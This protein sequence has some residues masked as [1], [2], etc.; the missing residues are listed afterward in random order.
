M[1]KKEAKT[2]LWVYD[3]LKEAGIY[4]DPQGCSIK[5]VDEA[6]KTASKKGTGNVGYPEYAGVV[7]DFLLV[8]ED[9]SDLSKHVKYDDKDLISTDI[10]AVTD[11]AVNGAY[12]Y[13]KHLINNTH[14][15]KIIAFGVSGNEKHHKLR[16]IDINR[17]SDHR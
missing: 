16:Q 7:G 11:Y 2:D 4:L 10:K 3:L 9:K 14:Y 8:I 15:K 1:A 13:G 5:E 12:F 17:K 6:L